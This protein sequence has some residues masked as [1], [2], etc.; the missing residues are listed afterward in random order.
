MRCWK[1]AAPMLRL[2]G[3]NRRQRHCRIHRPHDPVTAEVMRAG[4][5]PCAQQGHGGRVP[6]LHRQKYV[7]SRGSL[8]FRYLLSLRDPD[9]GDP[10]A[11]NGNTPSKQGR[12]LPVRLAESR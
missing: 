10:L 8:R 5:P 3:S 4:S 11:G 2:E 12:T 7:R 6:L 1:A 9:N